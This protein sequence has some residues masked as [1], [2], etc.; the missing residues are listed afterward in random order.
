VQIIWSSYDLFNW[1][2]FFKT[3]AGIAGLVFFGEAFSHEKAINAWA[4]TRL[5]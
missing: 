3:D 1:F 5:D 2:N 4:H